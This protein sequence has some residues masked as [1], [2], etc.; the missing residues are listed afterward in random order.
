MHDEHIVSTGEEIKNGLSKCKKK[1][2]NKQTNKQNKTKQNK[3]TIKKNNQTNKQIK[4]KKKRRKKKNNH[5]NKQKTINVKH[6]S[7]C[8]IY[9]LKK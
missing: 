8:F 5:T 9:S 3:Q 4:P 1:K 7:I 2:P 6:M